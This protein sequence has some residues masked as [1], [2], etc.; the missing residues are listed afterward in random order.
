MTGWSN[1]SGS[2]AASPRQLAKPRTA[3]E[4]A[5]LVTQARKVRVVGAGHSFM[6]LCETGDLLLNLS[7]YE[8]AVEIAP[9]RKTVWAPAGWSL[10][11]LT[12]ALWTEGLSLINQGDVNPQSLAG[13]VSTGT[14]G[15]GA[16]LGSLS[17]QVLG[18]RLMTAD[19][20]LVECGPDLNPDL[21]EA[22]RLSLGLL[23]VAVAI[24]IQVAP[25]YHLEERIERRPLAEV[26]ERMDE[27][28]AATR[29]MEFF[30][31]PYSDDV[32]LKSLH[33]IAPTETGRAAREIGDESEG[34]FRAICDL[35]AALPALTPALQRLVMRTMGK[36]TRRV[37]PAYEIFPAERNIRFEEMEYELP[38]AWGV[39]TL[40]A[41][42]AHI[43]KRR[44]PITF[45]LEFRLVA[46]DDIWMSPFNA[47]PG[48]SVS[49]H[50]YAKMP[51]R[52][53][54][55]EIEAV[56]RDGGGRPHWAKRH[57]LT[58]DDVHRLYPRVGDFLRVRQAWDPTA[59]FANTHLT[60]LFGL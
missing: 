52:P 60:Q 37:G 17:T 7:D 16:A 21:H 46:G 57:T 20:R 32:I 8:G 49:L 47:G 15:T 36:A 39:P 38:R 31:F 56:M 43:R 44:L 41:A 58:A 14:H 45:P 51:W 5:A 25:A 9:D 40:K 29:H 30:V 11:R 22:Q 3:A 33:P 4:L 19:G 35:C 24:R 55:A 2:V 54:F 59:K 13:A 28:S 26:A 34:A 53:A 48:A 50:Q 27:L 10:K 1:W 23:G 42:I 6:P 18:F 12:A